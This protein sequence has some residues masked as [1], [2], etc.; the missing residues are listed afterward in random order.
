M[1]HLIFS[2]HC[3]YVKAFPH[4]IK[5]S[6]S[7]N[8]VAYLID[9]AGV[10]TCWES[11]KDL[12]PDVTQSMWKRDC[13]FGVKIA[14]RSHT[15]NRHQ[16]FAAQQRSGL[17][18]QEEQSLI[19][20][21][22]KENLSSKF[23]LKRSYTYIITSFSFWFLN[24]KQDQPQR[25]AILLRDSRTVEHH[26]LNGWLLHQ[27]HSER[28]TY[29]NQFGYLDVLI[30]NAVSIYH[31]RDLKAALDTSKCAAPVIAF[32]SQSSLTERASKSSSTRSRPVWERTESF[33]CPNSNLNDLLV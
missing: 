3:S 6:S 17:T 18:H 5:F 12:E 8:G 19:S 20:P 2:L 7:L 23:F 24:G 22:L 13:E 10:R 9:E 29:L 15:P 1:L 4:C 25:L 14:G 26:P 28:G 27:F 32:A 30:K 31:Y 11:F 21:F 33:R 16:R